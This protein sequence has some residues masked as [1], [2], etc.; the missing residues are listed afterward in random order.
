MAALE[1]VEQLDPT[2]HTSPQIVATF[3]WEKAYKDQRLLPADQAAVR[4]ERA[5]PRRDRALA[6]KPDYVRR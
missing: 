2:D 5:L 3:Y 1:A 4:H 6:L